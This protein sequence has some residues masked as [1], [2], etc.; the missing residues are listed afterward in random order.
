MTARPRN[1]GERQRI[2]SKVATTSQYLA[3]AP[4]LVSHLRAAI[5]ARIEDGLHAASY[6]EPTRGGGTTA[7]APERAAMRE[8][9]DQASEDLERLDH[10]LAQWA[11]AEELIHLFAHRR[12]PL[13]APP[14]R[15]GD[16]PCPTG[17][18]ADHWRARIH[19][20]V[21]KKRYANWCRQ[22]GEHR[23]THGTSIPEPVLHAAYHAG[24]HSGAHGDDWQHWS[25]KRAWDACRPPE[26]RPPQ[27]SEQT[28]AD[29]DRS[30]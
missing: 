16:G 2:V 10:A 11:E 20:K 19:R 8:R 7:T 24:L 18:C 15:T 17:L 9:A 3:T 6:D 13:T 30:A 22:C 5:D 28:A 4:H 23:A 14:P 21:A 29:Q 27:S 25:V 12:Y 26:T 1:D